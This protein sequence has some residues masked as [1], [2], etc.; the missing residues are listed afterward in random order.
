MKTLI[1]ESALDN[2]K[3]DELTKKCDALKDKTAE[4]FIPEVNDVQ[5]VDDSD[6]Q[7]E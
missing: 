4:E 7:S 1:K 5:L 6:F 3:P 2:V